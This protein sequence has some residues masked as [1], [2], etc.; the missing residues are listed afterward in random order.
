M[1]ISILLETSFNCLMVRTFEQGF[2][3]Q[4]CVISEHDL[5]I[6]HD[7][8][9]KIR[10]ILLMVFSMHLLLNFHSI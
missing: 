1:L 10:K 3:T 2:G 5:L 7:E 4:R 9:G 6:D 8:G